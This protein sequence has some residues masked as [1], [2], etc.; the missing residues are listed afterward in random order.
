MQVFYPN[1]IFAKSKFK[2]L[3]GLHPEL[4]ENAGDHKQLTAVIA[5]NA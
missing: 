5:G 2:R 1:H 3:Q 4:S